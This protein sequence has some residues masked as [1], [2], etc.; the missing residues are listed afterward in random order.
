MPYRIDP[1]AGKSYE[2]AIPESAVKARWISAALSKGATRY[3]PLTE[4]FLMVWMATFPLCKGL[5]DV[6]A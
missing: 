4:P 2:R 6:G 3:M 1:A 5:L